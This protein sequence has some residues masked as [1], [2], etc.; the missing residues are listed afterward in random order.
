MAKRI[1]KYGVFVTPT[2]QEISVEMDMVRYGGRFLNKTTGKMAGEGLSFHF[3][4]ACQLA[5]P[6]VK[7]HKW[8]E[9]IVKEY[10]ANRGL[11]IIGPK[12]SGKTYTM[13]M[14]ALMDYYI[15]PTQTTILLVSTKRELL[16]QRIWGEM[17][18][19]HTKAKALYNWL[20]GHLIQSR[21]RLVT[22]TKEELTDGA[23]FKN[24]I[25][26]VPAY[27]GSVF[28]GLGAFVGVKNKRVRL[29]ADEL[30]LLP[31]AVV[32]AISNLDSNP[33]FKF[34]G[35]GNPKETTDAL[36]LM[37]EPAASLGGWDGGID[38]TPVTKTWQCRRT[39]TVAV[40]LVGSDSPNIDGKLGIPLIDQEMIDRDISFYG[41]DSLQYTMMNQG[42]MPRGQGAKRVITRQLCLKHHA[43]D[44]P[45]WLNNVRKRLACLD[46]AYMG[47]GGDRCVFGELNFGAESTESI[48]IAS[49][50]G[51]GLI[52]ERPDADSRP[53]IL[54]LVDT[55]I[56]P[57]NPAFFEKVSAE[58]QIVQFV[59]SQCEQRGIPPENFYFDAGMRTS[60]VT[61]FSRIWSPR[62]NSIDCGGSA[63]QR[64]VSHDI[65]VICKD[66]YSKFITELWWS[67]RLVI[68]SGQFRGMT[69]DVMLEFCA[70]EWG[71]SKSNKIEVETKDQMKLKTGRSPD[72]ADTIAIG[73]EGARQMG[74]TIRRLANVEHVEQDNR[75]KRDLINRTRELLRSKE[76][77]SA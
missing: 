36:G 32:D 60:L 61:A 66:Y 17:V 42:M 51:Q 68:E 2:A 56:I 59:R 9:L 39:R 30:S 48:D 58:E 76:L 16:I 37:A 77:Q 21:L 45:V 40:Q 35:L 64:R 23:D 74:F 8:N 33:D 14:C 27:E 5:W 18:S 24:G 38:Q 55:Q 72:L 71:M 53:Q 7:W 26:G 11:V 67:V 47:V 54:A 3:K 29:I 31:R 10:L 25:L 22:S 57:I 19:M 34:V 63:S 28:R 62:V 1:E 44:D 65:D 70:R 43:L 12:S 20:P 73:V 52:G 13:A 49:S 46:A 69:E 75:W 6:H 4:R 15:F 50:V 41:K